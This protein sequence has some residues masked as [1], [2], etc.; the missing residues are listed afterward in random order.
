MAALANARGTVQRDKMR[1][2]QTGRAAPSPNT[3]PSPRRAYPSGQTPVYANPFAPSARHAP[4]DVRGYPRGQS[5]AHQTQSPYARRVPTMNS[6]Y[7]PNEYSM[8]YGPAR[9]P[10][11][12]YPPGYWDR[13]RSPGPN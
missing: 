5:Q 3:M 2:Q 8:R 7:D 1:A 4:E 9:A 12:R 6:T 11:A 13:R 10:S